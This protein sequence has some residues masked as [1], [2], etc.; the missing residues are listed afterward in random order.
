[1]EFLYF[2]IAGLFLYVAADWLLLRIEAMYGG[3]LPHRSLYFFAI[4]LI[5]TMIVFELIQRYAP[6]EAPKA[7]PVVRAPTPPAAESLPTGPSFKDPAIKKM[8]EEE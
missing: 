7:E 5:M 3:I 2:T 8:F 4:I 1:M 6:P